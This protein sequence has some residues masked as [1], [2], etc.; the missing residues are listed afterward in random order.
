M[1]HMRILLKKAG[2]K[3]VVLGDL[4]N[5]SIA[6]SVNAWDRWFV[7]Q[8]RCKF[9]TK[10]ATSELMVKGRER[11]RL[12]SPNKPEAIKGMTRLVFRARALA[13]HDLNNN[14]FSIGKERIARQILPKHRRHKINPLRHRYQI[15]TH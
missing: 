4:A 11:W 1:F 3:P 14:A 7:P 8:K 12:A 2:N 15:S 10:T 9:L 13:W 5:R 6:Q